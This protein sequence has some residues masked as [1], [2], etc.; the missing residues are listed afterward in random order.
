[1]CFEAQGG[2]SQ[3]SGRLK[4]RVRRERLVDEVAQQAHEAAAVLDD[5]LLHVPPKRVAGQDAEIAADIGD[6]GTD[7][8]TADF[9]GDLLCGGQ[10]G[11]TRIGAAR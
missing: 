4:P 1:M 3:V 10:A 6:D 9:G 5:E 11:E 8:A 7:R 2:C